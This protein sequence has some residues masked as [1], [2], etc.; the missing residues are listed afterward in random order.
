LIQI[1]HG[2][3]TNRVYSEGKELDNGWSRF[4]LYSTEGKVKTL[5]LRG[6]G[7]RVRHALGVLKKL[8]FLLERV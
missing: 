8:S 6:A 5:A 7:E 1:T 3:K 2:K 4:G